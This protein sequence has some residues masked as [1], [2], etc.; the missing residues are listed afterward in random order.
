MSKTKLHDDFDSIPD[1]KD[2]TP[3]DSIHLAKNLL[4]TLQT[5]L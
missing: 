3:W 5:S 1:L 4:T 2:L